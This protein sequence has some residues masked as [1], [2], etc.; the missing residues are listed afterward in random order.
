MQIRRLSL[1]S[2]RITYNEFCM[3]NFTVEYFNGESLSL[4]EAIRYIHTGLEFDNSR[5]FSNPLNVNDIKYLFGTYLEGYE[6]VEEL[7]RVGSL[8]VCGASLEEITDDLNRFYNLRDE[9]LDNLND[10]KFVKQFYNID[11]YLI[12]TNKFFYLLPCYLFDGKLNKYVKTNI[13]CLCFCKENS[14][15]TSVLNLS[16]LALVRGIDARSYSSLYSFDI[17][18]R[19]TEYLTNSYPVVSTSIVNKRKSSRHFSVLVTLASDVDKEYY[20]DNIKRIDSIAIKRARE[21]LSIWE[22]PQ[23]MFKISRKKLYNSVIYYDVDIKR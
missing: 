14:I 9:V 15:M 10:I 19:E 2:K 7:V 11:V 8:L 16:T 17:F 21:V 18:K 22:L 5:T 20:M 6:I 4:Y 13:E 12:V 1:P 3:Y 23:S